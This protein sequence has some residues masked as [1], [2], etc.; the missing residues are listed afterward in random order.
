[1]NIA[2]IKK[3]LV[4]T[5]SDIEL[6]DRLTKAGHTICLFSA[7]STTNINQNNYASFNIT[8]IY[9]FDGIAIAL[10]TFA[11][12]KLKKS[13]YKKYLVYSNNNV[14][15]KHNISTEELGRLCLSI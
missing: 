2:I 6:L 1:L 10:D 5:Q 9:C 3:D 14:L 4:F 13:K 12:N 11:I 7:V 8:Y 15:D